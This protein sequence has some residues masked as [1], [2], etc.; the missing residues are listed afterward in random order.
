MNC[1]V[2]IASFGDRTLEQEADHVRLG[3]SDQLDDF[4]WQ[5]VAILFQKTVSLIYDS[6]GKM[7]DREADSIRFWSYVEFGFDVAVELFYK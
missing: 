3:L 1:R 4:R 5:E 6:S 7:M 2:Q